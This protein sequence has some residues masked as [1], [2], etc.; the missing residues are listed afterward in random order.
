MN[1]TTNSSIKFTKSD[2]I[3]TFDNPRSYNLRSLECAKIMFDFSNLPTNFT[4]ND[5]FAIIILDEEDRQ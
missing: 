4:Y 3:A 5:H 2:F 1:T